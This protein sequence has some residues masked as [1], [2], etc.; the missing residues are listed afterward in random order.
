LRKL[1]LLL[2]LGRREVAAVAAIVGRLDAPVDRAQDQA[3]R[4]GAPR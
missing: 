1:G 4:G 3:D 2:G